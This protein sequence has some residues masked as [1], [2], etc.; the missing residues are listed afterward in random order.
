[1][2]FGFRP[3]KNFCR[4]AFIAVVLL[5]FNA[6]LLSCNTA[7]NSSE[8]YGLNSRPQSKPYLQMPDRADGAQPR[9][10]SQTGAFQDTHRLTPAAPLIPYDLIV[11]FWSDG[12]T[13]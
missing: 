1:M 11:P 10:L 2:T 5:A 7:K 12:A 8:P 9:L 6:A 4:G 13:K 3:A